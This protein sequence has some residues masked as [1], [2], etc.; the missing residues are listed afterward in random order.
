MATVIRRAEWILAFDPERGGHVYR[1]DGDVAWDGDRI[2]QVGG[3]YTGPAAREIDGRGRLVMPGLVD[4]HSHPLSEPP[5]KGWTD[6]LGSPSLGMS[7]LYEFMPIYRP[8]PEGMRACAR[9]P[10]A[11]LLLSGVTTL[12]DLSVVYEGWLEIMAE[13]GLRV[14]AA[15]MFRSVHWSIRDGSSVEYTWDEAAGFRAMEGRGPRRD[16]HRH[17][18]A[19]HARGAPRG[20][21]LLTAD[22]RR[23]L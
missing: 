10:M 17:L 21:L 5:N 1:T 7:S 9:L 6:E 23:S 22:D 14:V 13:S 20:P 2:L 19:Q 15:P 4:I 12:V 18:P 16:R 8:D 3:G 11:E